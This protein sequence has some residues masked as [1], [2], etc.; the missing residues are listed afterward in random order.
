MV[1]SLLPALRW[2]AEA[3]V[4]SHNVLLFMPKHQFN[5]Q[6]QDRLVHIWKSPRKSSVKLNNDF[7]LRA[8]LADRDDI[9]MMLFVLDRCGIWPPLTI[10]D[11]IFSTCAANK[12]WNIYT[13][14]NFKKKII[15]FFSYFCKWFEWLISPDAGIHRESWT[16]ADASQR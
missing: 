4:Y 8:V 3:C 6:H 5:N 11:V 9:N 1:A 14:R 7:I 2:G 15:F 10:S 16:G 13:C 12:R